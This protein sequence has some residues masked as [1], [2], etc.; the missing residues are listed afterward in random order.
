MW[1]K[2]IIT[3]KAGASSCRTLS[4]R[5]QEFSEDNKFIL[6]CSSHRQIIRRPVMII[7][8]VMTGHEL[9]IR[10]KGGPPPFDRLFV[11][12]RSTLVRMI[13]PSLVKHLR[14][15]KCLARPIP[16]PLDFLLVKVMMDDHGQ[17][18]QLDDRPGIFFAP[19]W[20]TSRSYLDT[21]EPLLRHDCNVTFVT[22]QQQC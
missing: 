18:D 13:D 10:G 11:A 19:F 7:L 8:L 14:A 16:A 3:I 5:K 6:I 9:M 4:G 21:A 2:V 15:R 20:A 1:K 22:T 17:D 12:T